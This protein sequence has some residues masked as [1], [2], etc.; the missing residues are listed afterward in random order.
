[1]TEDIKLPGALLGK[2]WDAG[3]ATLNGWMSLPSAEAAEVLA[4]ENWDTLTLDMQHGMI[5]YNAALPMLTAIAGTD[6]LPMVR[7]PW[8]DEGFVMKMLDAGAW[9]IIC[10]MINS[11]EDA[12]R[13]ALACRFP[14]EGSRSLG[15]AMARIRYGAPYVPQANQSTYSFAMI[16]TREA[17]ENLEDILA[18]EQL[19]GVY[20]GPTDLSFAYG[21]E[22][23][24]DPV[25]PEIVALMQHIISTAKARGKRV[26]V[27][28]ATVEYAQ[29][30]IEWGA[31]LVTVSA[32]VKFL[33]AG[34]KAVVSAFRETS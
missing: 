22:P 31:D 7:I 29:K 32:D 19:S 12:E 20:I 8:L 15:Q 24:F 1:M 14:P 3:E 5:D 13:L 10:P 9:G 34:A 4:R 18:V 30:V 33:Q 6:T 28:N 21:A 25:D 16:E 23:R 2:K 17:V 11:G 27:H 26:G